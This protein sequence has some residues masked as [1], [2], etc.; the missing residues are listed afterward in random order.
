M[1]FML[2]FW[3]FSDAYAEEPSLSMLVEERMPTYQIIQ[4]YVDI[5]EVHTPQE[6]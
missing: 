6:V 3:L 5:T 2:F 4:I 1:L